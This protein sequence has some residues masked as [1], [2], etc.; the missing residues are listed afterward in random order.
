MKSRRLMTVA[1]VSTLV[2]GGVPISTHAASSGEDA[3]KGTARAELAAVTVDVDRANVMYSPADDGLG[4]NYTEVVQYQQE[5]MAG[6]Q[7]FENGKYRDALQHLRKADQIIR[8]RPDWT[9]SE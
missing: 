2:L 9:E 4:S 3:Q 1:L 7:S 8:S 6:R 5:Y